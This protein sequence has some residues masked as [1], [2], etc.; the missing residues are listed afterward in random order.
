MSPEVQHP[1]TFRMHEGESV[2]AKAYP[3]IAAEISAYVDAS[4]PIS[5][6][7]AYNAFVHGITDIIANHASELAIPT[8]TFEKEMGP[9]QRQSEITKAVPWGGVSFQ[10]VN[11]PENYIQKLLV[12]QQRGILGFE[13]HHKKHEALEV[14]DGYALIFASSHDMPGWQRGQVKL[15]FA[16]VGDSFVLPP[17]DEHG[18]IALTNC[19]VQE[20]SDNELEA[21]DLIFVFNSQQ[22]L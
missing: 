5:D 13:L 6:D 10:H 9:I 21:A 19:I 11:V 16:G 4:L 14:L 12:I 1:Y 20:T 3:E 17:E 18:M 7:D 22:V 2:F 15:T 8:A